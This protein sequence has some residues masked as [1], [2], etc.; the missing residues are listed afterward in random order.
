MTR[1]NNNGTRLD[2]HGHKDAVRSAPHMI[3][4]CLSIQ[5]LQQSTLGRIDE[6]YV[7]E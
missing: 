3:K 7:K 6:P 1:E 4:M 5:S 2:G